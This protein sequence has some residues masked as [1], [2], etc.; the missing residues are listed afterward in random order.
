MKILF[1][2]DNFPPE[3]NAPAKRT[4]EHTKNWAQSGHEV[5]VITGVPN[6]P[7]GKVF[8][9][10]KN[11]L[12][13][14]ETVKNINVKRVW[15]Y[16]AENKGFMLRIID[17]VSFMISSF[18]CGIFTKKNDIVIATSP[19]FFSAISGYLISLFKK[20]HYILEIRDLWPESIVTVGAMKESSLAIKIL[21]KIALFLYRR[22]KIIVCVTD[23][24]KQDLINKGIDSD[25]I[26]VIRNG[27]NFENILNPTKTIKQVEKAYNLNCN[28]F[29]ISFIGTI[30]M[31][32]GLNVILKASK[33]ID[34]KVKFLIVGD[35]AE[36]EILKQKAQNDSINNVIFISSISWQ[37]IINLN[38]IISV[39]LVHLIDSPEFRKVIPSK[40]FESMAFKKPIIMGVLGE[41][42]KIIQDAKCGIEMIP[43]NPESLKE[44]INILLDNPS[45]IKEL[46]ENGYK[47]VKNNYNRHHLANQMIDFIKNKL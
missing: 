23:S 29:I 28:D 21:S 33:N 8:D 11:K 6:F 31:A 34:K 19:Q 41:A 18:I 35:G 3:R 5:T 46:G 25:K 24:F 32:H 9:G 42:N 39:N 44:V 47:C 16:I 10:Y 45:M 13:Q 7:V 2:T 4:F 26:I 12:F 14:K 17:Y 27:F 15:T 40:I 30:G 22:A 37:E 43:E 1:I 38:Q 36:K 20:S